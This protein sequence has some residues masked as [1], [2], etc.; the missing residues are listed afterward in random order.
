MESET[1]PI[2]EQGVV[3][4]LESPATISEKDQHVVPFFLDKQRSGDLSHIDHKL[5]F[6]C[7][8]IDNGLSDNTRWHK[9]VAWECHITERICDR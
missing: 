5:P 1:Q 8:T 9:C 4:T 6:A 2:A 7:L 3:T